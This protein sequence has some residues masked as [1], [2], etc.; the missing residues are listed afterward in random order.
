MKLYEGKL[1]II[2]HELVGALIDAELIE[3]LPEEREEAELDVQATLREYLR[4]EHE[5]NE[6]AR[7]ILQIRGL[8]FSAFFR[9]K[10]GLADEKGIAIGDEAV[11]YLVMQIIE[12]FMHSAHVEEV[13]GEDREL[14]VKMGPVIKKHTEMEDEL[15]REV[16]DKIKNLEE[17]TADWEIE[18]ARV[19]DNVKRVKKL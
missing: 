11:D 5:I 9:I 6:R 18:Y 17:G 8:D 12:Q 15:D 14:R 19:M 10:K 13:F 3:V 16:R 1:P 2:A 7:E 4:V